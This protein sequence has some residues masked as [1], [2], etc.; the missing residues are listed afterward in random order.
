MTDCICNNFPAGLGNVT[1]G[2]SVGIGMSPSP[3]PSE[4]LQVAGGNILVGQGYGFYIGDAGHGIRTTPGNPNRV[5]II[6]YNWGS[7]GNSYW[8]FVDSDGNVK[9]LSTL[10]MG[11]RALAPPIPRPSSMWRETLSWMVPW[12]RSMVDPT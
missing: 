12:L 11:E 8:R 7:P 6:N 3:G 1:F 4:R 10:T 5:D 9:S 2:A